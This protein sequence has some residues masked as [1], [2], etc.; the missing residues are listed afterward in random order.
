MNEGEKK[1]VVPGWRKLNWPWWDTHVI[2]CQMC[3]QMIPRDV[4]VAEDGL[5]FC[6]EECD[7]LYRTYWLPRYG[8][9]RK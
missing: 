5:E 4:W 3:G 6:T 9:D 2:N 7:S 8:P 1:A